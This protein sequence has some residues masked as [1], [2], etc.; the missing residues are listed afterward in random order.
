MSQ[1][2]ALNSRDLAAELR[3]LLHELDPV[4][5]K[6]H[7]AETR[8]EAV[9][10]L[11]N[12]LHTLIE[13]AE[14]LKEHPNVAQLH[15]HLN[16]LAL[17]IDQR[18]PRPTLKNAV[19]AERWGE[20][21][22]ALVP[23]YERLATS[24]SAFDIHVPSLRP[25]NHLRSLWHATNGLMVLACIQTIFTTPTALFWVG[26]AGASLA[27]SMEISRRLSSRINHLL[28]KLFRHLAHPHEE[29]RVNS[30]TWYCTAMF[31]LGILG[32]AMIGSIAVVVLGLADPAAAW[33][34]RRWGQV[35]LVNGR[36]LEGSSAFA[37]VGTISAFGVMALLY[38]N[39]SLWMALTLS[40]VAGL[41]GAV[42]ELLCRRVDDN[43][44]EEEIV[45]KR[46]WGHSTPLEALRMLSHLDAPPSLVLSH[47]DPSHDD[48]TMDSI[49]EHTRRL[50]KDM[51]I[52]VL[53]AR[54][55]GVFE[56]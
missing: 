3:E 8:L 25:T 36:T 42:T 1:A 39:I 33:V 12:R 13:S 51:G 38:P 32:D 20:L 54:E 28:M 44:T 15:E 56:L 48:D 19:L 43:F 2:L 6:V 40:L 5:W 9:V 34:G 22:L 47:H 23:H 41:V 52:E 49:L 10:A 46:H 17:E 11:R 27:W 37:L 53:I 24:L 7:L 16:N 18:L 31:A 35:Q 55:G 26:F 45:G 14:R 29:W 21:R 4:R 30:A 50:G